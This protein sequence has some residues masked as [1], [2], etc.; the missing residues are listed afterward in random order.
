MLANDRSRL[1]ATD[2]DEAGES[3]VV[4]FDHDIPL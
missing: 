4:R 3:P 1:N 2:Q